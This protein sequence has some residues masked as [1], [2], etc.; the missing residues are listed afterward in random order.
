MRLTESVVHLPFD[1]GY[2]GK[3]DSLD[4][5]DLLFDGLRKLWCLTSMFDAFCQGIVRSTVE[6]HLVENVFDIPV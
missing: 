5:E 1:K 3:C 4:V 6:S 2:Q